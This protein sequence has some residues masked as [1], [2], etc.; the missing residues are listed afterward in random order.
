[1]WRT[2]RETGSWS[3]EIWNQ[4]RDGSVFPN[5]C[6]SPPC[7]RPSGEVLHYVGTFLD[8]TERK[9]AETASA[10]WPS[11]TPHRAAQPQP[12][13]RPIAQAMARAEQNRRVA[14]L[15]PDLDRFKTINDSL[16]HAIGRPAAAGRGRPPPPAGAPA[17]R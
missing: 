12:A 17:T 4:R 10:S 9:E 8:L 11:S 7:A 16:G 13:G 3:G 5:C 15:V 1:M 14:A 2:I 6:R